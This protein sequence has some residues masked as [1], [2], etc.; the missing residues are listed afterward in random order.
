MSERVPLQVVHRVRMP[1]ERQHPGLPPSTESVARL[2]PGLT[3]KRSRIATV[4]GVAQVQASTVRVQNG[5][6]KLGHGITHVRTLR[7]ATLAPKLSATSGLAAA[8]ANVGR[9]RS[10]V[11]LQLSEPT[12]GR[13]SLIWVVIP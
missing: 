1:A 10:Q 12:V 8:H 3:G 11:T 13:A 4:R 2:W 7:R 6:G 9:A 5:Q